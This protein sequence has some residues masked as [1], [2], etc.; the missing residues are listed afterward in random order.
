MKSPQ[1]EPGGPRF[2]VSYARA[3]TIAGVSAI[4]CATSLMAI[5]SAN[6]AVPTF[7]DNLVV[8]PDRDFI[9]IEGYQDLSLIH[10]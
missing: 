8:F 5:P 7:P 6:A 10:I 9:T 4:L 1:H 3:G 2:R